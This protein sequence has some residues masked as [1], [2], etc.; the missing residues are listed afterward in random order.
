MSQINENIAETP[1]NKS[2][3]STYFIMTDGIN[4]IPCPETLLQIAETN[5]VQ[6]PWQ[7]LK[8]TLKDTILKQCAVIEAQVT[9]TEIISSIDTVKTSII[10]TIDH[11]SGPPFTIQRV[12]ELVTR[13]TQHYKVFQKYLYAI[14]KVLLVQ[15][16][17]ELFSETDE[18]RFALD[19]SDNYGFGDQ[20]FAGGQDLE[21]IPFE[22]DD[23]EPKDD[24]DDENENISDKEDEHDTKETSLEAEQ[25]EVDQVMDDGDAEQKS[26]EQTS[27]DDNEAKDDTSVSKDEAGKDDTKTNTDDATES[28]ETPTDKDEQKGTE[29]ASSNT[30]HHTTIEGEHNIE[31]SNKMD[32]DES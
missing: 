12:C 28:A 26:P 18:A 5:Q 13:P 27:T 3:S 9:D 8:E 11:H 6:T 14:E 30:P 2:A 22:S 32:V 1:V 15:S 10:H 31:P 17:W 21:P 29:A 7:E 20:N 16:N 19:N 4:D 25:T 24:E 23:S